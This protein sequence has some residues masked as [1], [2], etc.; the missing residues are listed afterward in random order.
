MIS[1][2]LQ[3]QIERLVIKHRNTSLDPG[4][5][6]IY[7]SWK[8]MVYLLTLLQFNCLP[9]IHLF[10]PM[11]SI[12]STQLL[13]MNVSPDLCQ[14]T[15]QWICILA[16]QSYSLIHRLWYPIAFKVLQIRLLKY[17][18]HII[19]ST[20]IFDGAKSA[21]MR[22]LTGVYNVLTFPKLTSMYI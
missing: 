8:E 6:F 3:R 2:P 15:F 14:V 12:I 13:I 4:S 16:S 5:A 11:V 17:Y 21:S 7:C 19:V 20:F 18:E 22:V 9:F 1:L 10:N